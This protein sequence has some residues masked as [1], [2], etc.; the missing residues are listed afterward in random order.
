MHMLSEDQ[1]GSRAG[2]GQI[3]APSVTHRRASLTL[4]V[5]AAVVIVAT[6]PASPTWAQAAGEYRGFGLGQSLSSVAGRIGLS[7]ND[8]TAVHLRPARI[9]NLTWRPSYLRDA[10]VAPDPVERIVFSFYNDH[11]FRVTV[12]YDSWRTAGMTDDDMVAALTAVYGASARPSAGQDIQPPAIEPPSIANWGDAEYG[13]TLN[14]SAYGRNFRLVVTSRSLDR[15][16]TTAAA[17]AVLLDAGEA[18]ARELARQ[19]AADDEARAAEQRARDRNRPA[20]KP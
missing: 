10:A 11:L 7:V 20:F 9:H 15:L 12:D 1:T 17:Q 4:A 3:C 19:R 18:P 8:A 16:A 13:V 6:M 14:R 5:A 2:R